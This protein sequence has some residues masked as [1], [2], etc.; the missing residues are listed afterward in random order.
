MKAGALQKA[1]LGWVIIRGSHTM[2]KRAFW[3]AP[4][5]QTP[6]KFHEK[7]PGESTKSAIPNWKRKKKAR[8]FGPPPFGAPP[9]ENPRPSGPSIFLGWRPAFG[10]FADFVCAVLLFFIL[11][12]CCAFAGLVFGAFCC[13]DVVFRCCF[14]SGHP[15]KAV[16][17]QRDASKT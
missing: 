16:S 3:R 2:T 10:L 11:F 17:A 8:N 13:F 5:L 9:V 15:K 14:Q 1:R 6:P 4:T 7:T 12:S